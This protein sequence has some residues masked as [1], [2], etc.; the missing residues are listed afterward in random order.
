MNDLVRPA[1]YEAWHVRQRTEAQRERDDVVGPV[2]ETADYLGL[3]REL[4]VE[5]GELLAVLCAG[6][7]GATMSS[8]YKTRPRAPEVM[9]DAD[10]GHLVRGRDTI[11]DLMRGEQ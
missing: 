6:A 8:N 7:Y 10:R 2:C 5:D 1:L 11:E 3:D 4:A 9:V